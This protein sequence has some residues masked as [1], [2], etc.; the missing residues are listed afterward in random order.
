MMTKARSMDD[1]NSGP[2][3]C[4]TSAFGLKDHFNIEIVFY[5]RNGWQS[6][7]ACSLMGGSS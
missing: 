2:P 5:G 3:N 7:T 4:R 6:R 1:Y